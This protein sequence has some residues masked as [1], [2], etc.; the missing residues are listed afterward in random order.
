MDQYNWA[1]TNYIVLSK[2]SKRTSRGVEGIQRGLPVS[3]QPTPIPEV[4]T[5]P[6][7]SG[8]TRLSWGNSGPSLQFHSTPRSSK[9][10]PPKKNKWLRKSPFFLTN[11]FRTPGL[12]RLTRNNSDG[13]EDFKQE[14]SE[15]D[16]VMLCHLVFLSS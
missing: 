14:T 10:S 13:F 1:H 5:S 12:G 4:K 11:R 2:Q 3:T 7:T 9:T 8:K 15:F 6:Y 16:L